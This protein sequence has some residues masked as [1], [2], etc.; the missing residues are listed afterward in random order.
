MS[1]SEQVRE[2][3]IANA[4][5]S[6]D[7]VIRAFA[8]KGILVTKS[9]IYNARSLNRIG[10]ISKSNENVGARSGITRMRNDK[11]LREYITE[12]LGKS[13]DGI[14]A[15]VLA[16]KILQ[17][18]YETS[19]S[20]FPDQV[21]KSLAIMTQ[22]GKVITEKAESGVNLYRISS[23]RVT[24]LNAIDPD[25]LIELHRLSQRIGIDNLQ[26]YIKICNQLAKV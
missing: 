12:I 20:D 7:E 25:V 17:A 16:E 11:C 8:E 15:T 3:L 9:N 1:K 19:A 5:M 21:R 2:F 18:G 6:V 13:K 4:N 10:K 24:A 23:N 14:I 22:N 26:Q